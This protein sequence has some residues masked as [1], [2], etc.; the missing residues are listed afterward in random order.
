MLLEVAVGDGWKLCWSG[1]CCPAFSSRATRS[2][3]AGRGFCFWFWFF[4]CFWEGESGVAVVVIR[5]C[6]TCNEPIWSSFFLQC[7]E[8][9][10]QEG[11]TVKASSG[12]GLR[13]SINTYT[14]NRCCWRFLDGRM[15]CNFP[16]LLP[17]VRVRPK[18]RIPHPPSEKVRS[19]VPELHHSGKKG[20]SAQAVVR[21]PAHEPPGHC[22]NTLSATDSE[23]PASF[24]KGI[25]G[26]F[27]LITFSSTRRFWI[28][29]ES[30]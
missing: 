5:P 25:L 23:P 19:D 4:V 28:V 8:G 16:N 14:H 21:V 18:P 2:G 29:L 1:R 27:H 9:E 7:S 30:L 17:T 6:K 11:G 20:E 24:K 10:A 22:S 3:G 15:L 12:S 26:N 13:A